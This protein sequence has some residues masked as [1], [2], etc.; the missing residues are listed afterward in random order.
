MS[1]SRA[2]LLLLNSNVL[3]LSRP[4]VPSRMVGPVSQK[5]HFVSLQHPCHSVGRC[6]RQELM[7]CPYPHA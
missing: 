5:L 7:P 4:L 1:P 3:M 6:M 2:I